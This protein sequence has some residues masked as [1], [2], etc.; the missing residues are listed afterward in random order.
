MPKIRTLII[1][2]YDSFTFNLHQAVAEITGTEPLVFYNDALDWRRLRELEFD[3]VIISPGPGRPERGRDFGICA[4]VITDLNV[5]LLGVCLGHQGIGHVF[6]AAVVHAPTPV[7]GQIAQI[8]HNGDPLFAGVD[9][10]FDGVRYHSL[11]VANPI[12]DCLE[13]IAWTDGDLVMALR[14]RSK[15]IWGVQFHPESI[16][17]LAGKTILENFCRM[18]ADWLGMTWRPVSSS[19]ASYSINRRGSSG[20]QRVFVKGIDEFVTPAQAF[21]HVFADEPYAFW[22]DCSTANGW[23]GGFSC[24]GG[25]SQDLAEI[26]QYDG[27]DRTLLVQRNGGTEVINEGA[28]TYLNRMLQERYAETPELPFD[29]NCGYI[30]YFGYEM[31]SEC[32]GKRLHAS[33]TPDCMLLFSKAQIVFH[34]REKKIYFVWYGAANEAE[35][36]NKWFTEIEG[37]LREACN[38]RPSPVLPFTPPILVPAQSRERY[39][40]RIRRSLAYIRAGESY[41]ICLTNKFHGTTDASPL[42]YYETLRSINPSPYSAFLKFGSLCISCSSPERFLRIRPDLTVETKPIK[43]TAPR[44]RTHAED[45]SLSRRLAQDV[46]TRS[47]N[48]MI[49]DLLRNDLGR[50]CEIGTVNVPKLMDVETYATVHQLV[51]TVRGRLRPGCTAVDCLHHAFPGG[52]MTGAPKL[53]TLEIIDELETEARGVYSGTIGFFALNGSADLNI[54]IRTAVFINGHVS[55]GTGGAIVALSD[56]E[57]EWDEVVLKA[58][59]LEMTFRSLSSV[60]PAEM[61]PA[62]R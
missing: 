11:I 1:D 22:L 4:K 58:K 57:S 37:R 56:P 48:L 33:A 41:E 9:S 46:K 21:R 17:T 15:P 27:A 52:S 5:P 36:A 24:I 12:P 47:E 45:E 35:Q 26:V 44:G 49:V 50:V 32:G 13:A 62:K 53:R 7:H 59:A 6:G 3:A 31:K 54:V 60:V 38:R 29:F 55:I 14:H 20:L 39:L 34:H 40:D 8:C 61:I 18:S 10:P 25:A 43:G 2:N 16:C 19:P 30:G 28:F 42:D 23:G 51:S